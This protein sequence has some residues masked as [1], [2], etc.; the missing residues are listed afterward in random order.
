MDLLLKYM[1][2]PPQLPPPPRPLSPV[3]ENRTKNTL[4]T[5]PILQ[6]L[7][8]SFPHGTMIFQKLISDCFITS[9][10]TFQWLSVL[11]KKSIHV[12]EKSTPLSSLL[13]Q[14]PGTRLLQTSQ[15]NSTTDS[16]T[17]CCFSLQTHPWTLSGHCPG[18]GISDASLV[19][20]ALTAVLKRHLHN[21]LP[22]PN[23]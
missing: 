5:G 6:L 22:R 18:L 20:P 17:S 14:A 21:R 10:K 3:M 1:P 13:H 16:H 15:V 2:D 7:Q 4:K 19:Q 23:S 11:M 8:A 12:L 9:F